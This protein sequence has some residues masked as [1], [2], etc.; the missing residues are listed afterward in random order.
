[1]PWLHAEAAAALG[2]YTDAVSHNVVSRNV[3]L[4]LSE[5]PI[6]HFGFAFHLVKINLI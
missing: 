5:N 4:V 6:Y 3:I 2:P 1:M